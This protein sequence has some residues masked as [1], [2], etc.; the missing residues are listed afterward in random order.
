MLKGLAILGIGA[1]G[2]AV[3]IPLVAGMVSGDN[4]A[5]KLVEATDRTNHQA[6]DLG[7]SYTSIVPL[8]DEEGNPVDEAEQLEENQLDEKYEEYASQAEHEVRDAMEFLHRL[9]T[10]AG[11][12]PQTEYIAA[13][14]E[15]KSAW[16]PR[17]KRAAD[18]YKV[19]AYRIHH[20]ESMAREY[21]EFQARLTRQIVNPEQRR[22]A[23]LQDYQE[24]EVYLQWRTQAHTTLS[25]ATLIKQDLDDLNIVITKLELSANFAALYQDFRELPPSLLTL[26]AEIDKFRD[27][28]RRINQT[29]GAGASLIQNEAGPANAP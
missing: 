15:L 25:R 20:A 7:D 26:H 10:E 21:F 4:Q 9:Q 28:T 11:P 14:R 27:E 24:Q 19:F 3:A 16:S 2:A 5:T 18:D 12:V 8:T 29:F 1:V 22:Q 23:E 17:Y 13:V 6:G